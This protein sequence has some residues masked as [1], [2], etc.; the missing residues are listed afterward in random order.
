MT[1]K[2]QAVVFD[3]D[4]VLID[5]RDWHYRALNEALDIFGAQISPDQ[6]ASRFNGLPT[7]VKL[8]ALT[9][10][11]LLPAHLHPVIEQVKQERTLREAANLCFPRVDHLLVLGWIR[12]QGCKLAVATNSVRATSTAMLE[13][14]G[15]LSLLDTLVTNE[16]VMNAKPAPEIYEEAC[17]RLHVKPQDTLVIEDHEY[18]VAAAVAAGCR[19]VRVDGVDDVTTTLLQKAFAEWEQL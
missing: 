16:D 8:E 19:V 7:R 14:A 2:P 5:A 17:R 15:V 1:T 13:F 3:M 18:G 12:G 11:G 9:E 6:H 4:G 10:E